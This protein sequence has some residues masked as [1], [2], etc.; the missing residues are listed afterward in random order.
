VP[1]FLFPKKALLLMVESTFPFIKVPWARISL[2]LFAYGTPLAPA[3]ASP[4]TLA[5]AIYTTSS[6]DLIQFP[7]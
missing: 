3:I 6:G 7:Y 5:E 2:S 4:T 1:L